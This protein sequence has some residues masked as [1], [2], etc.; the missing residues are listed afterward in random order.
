MVFATFAVESKVGTVPPCEGVQLY[1][2]RI[3]FHLT[4]ACEVAIDVDGSFL[5]LLE[6][7][8]VLFLH[9][10]LGLHKRSMCA[11]LFTETS[12]MPN[13]Y[14]CTILALWYLQYLLKGPPPFG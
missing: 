1:K 2:L 3:D 6:A 12:I 9:R 14:H 4:F 5:A 7:V 10:L 11:V 13:I 8:Q